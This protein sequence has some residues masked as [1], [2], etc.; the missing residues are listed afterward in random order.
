MNTTPFSHRL[1]ANPILVCLPDGK[2][3]FLLSRSHL[4]HHRD[5]DGA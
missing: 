2:K 1:D 3:A 4:G 5:V